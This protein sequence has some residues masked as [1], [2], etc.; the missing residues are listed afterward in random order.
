V[1]DAADKCRRAFELFVDVIGPI[2]DEREYR[3]ADWPTVP[4][5]AVHAVEAS[6]E[7]DGASDVS[8]ILT[9]QGVPEDSRTARMA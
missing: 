1:G 7:P 9:A 8:E 2:M 3:R 6:D 5:A 4:E